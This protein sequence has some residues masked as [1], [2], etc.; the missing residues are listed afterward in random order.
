MSET[1]AT[2]SAAAT[3]SITPMLE[4]EGL[5]KTYGR[6]VALDATDFA[7]FPGEVLAVIGDNGA[8]KSTLIKCLSGAEIPDNGVMRLDGEV[9]QFRKPI[10]ARNAGI[11]TVYQTLA[12]A[13]ALDI[14][15]N[16]FLGRELRKPG[17]V[18]SIMR[19]L[20]GSGMRKRAKAQMMAL[21]IGTLQ[22][23]NQAVETLSG[24]Q[25]Q[26]VAVARAAAFGSKVIILDEPTAALGVRESAQVLKLIQHLRDRGLPVILISHNMPQVFEVADRI[27]VQ[28]LGRRVA[29]ITPQTVSITDVVAIMTGALKVDVADQA[30][31]PVR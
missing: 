17:P 24:G 21:G 10:E 9:I 6:V 15:T 5:V 28:R 14:A 25:R 22:N 18:G 29:V 23:M 7:L 8:G 27:H 2:A 16:L 26:A 1:T 20:E 11:E 3:T 19:M 4:S 13:P 12:V 30:L 31:G